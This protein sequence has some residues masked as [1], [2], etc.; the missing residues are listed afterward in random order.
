MRT[1][2]AIVYVMSR[3]IVIRE[4]NPLC[5]PALSQAARPTLR[6]FA[7]KVQQ[8]IIRAAFSSAL[9]KQALDLVD[10]W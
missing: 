9:E 3:S 4:A 1:S 7:H 2:S 8:V 5:C 10:E 6:E